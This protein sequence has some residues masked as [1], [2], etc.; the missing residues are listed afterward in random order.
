[1]TRSDSIWSNGGGNGLIEQA[2]G[3]IPSQFHNVHYW[4]EDLY[5]ILLAPPKR[6]FEDFQFLM[7]LPSGLDSAVRTLSALLHGREQFV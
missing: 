2:N 3:T 1:M 5:H 4:E 6:P 7:D